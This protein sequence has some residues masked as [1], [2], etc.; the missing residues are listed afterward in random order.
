MKSSAISVSFC[1]PCAYSVVTSSNLHI[2]FTHLTSSTDDSPNDF[3]FL[4]IPAARIGLCVPRLEHLHHCSGYVPGKGRG[5]GIA[6]L[7]VLVAARAAELEVLREA[8]Q[9]R[10]LAHRD[11]PDEGWDLDMTDVHSFERLRM[12]TGEPVDRL[13][14]LQEPRVNERRLVAAHGSGQGLARTIQVDGTPHAVE[15]HPG[16][17]FIAQQMTNQTRSTTSLATNL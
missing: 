14:I 4:E 9:R 15:E 11:A 12:Q 5:D 10:R 2:P 7:P 3:L 16:I 6:D 13:R 17:R 8:L 1:H